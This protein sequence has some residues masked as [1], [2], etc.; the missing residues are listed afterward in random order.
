MLQEYNQVKKTKLNLVLFRFAIE[1]IS[2]IC[3]ILKLP[4]GNA[5]LVGVGGSGRQSLTLLSAFITE[6]EVFSIEISK[7]YSKVEWREDMKKLLLMTGRDNLKTVF[8]FPD[9]KIKEE[10]FIED[11]NGLLNSGDIPNLFQS[12]EKSQLIEKLLPIA[13]EEQKQGDSSPMQIYNYFIERVKKNLHIV[14]CMSPI[15]GI[16]R[17]RLRKFSSLVNCCTIDWFQRWPQDALQAVA[18]QFFSEIKIEKE[19]F[20]NVVDSCQYFHQYTITM[21]TKFLSA[22]NRYNYVTPT[23]YLELLQAYKLLLFK[24]RDQI[25][26]FRNRYSGGLEKL[27]FAAKQIAKMQSDLTDLQPQLK[28]TTE[29]TVTMLTK[30][31]KESVEVEETRKT[32]S[33]DEADAAQKAESSSAMKMECEN[34][35]AEAIPLL[36]AALTALDTLKKSDVDLVKSMKNPPAGVKLVMESICV[37]KDIKPDKI[38]DPTGSGKM[39]LDYWKP[40]QKLLGDPGFLGGL[41]TYDKDAIPTAVIKKIRDTYI[42]NP[43]FKPEKVKNASSAAE[44]LCSWV[45]A[46]EAYDRVIKVV[47]PKQAELQKAESELAA[48][49]VILNEKRSILK[50]VVERLQKLNDNLKELSDKKDR[51]EKEGNAKLTS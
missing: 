21:S 1:H 42:P 29:E 3:R 18:R 4:G 19:L 51:L 47:A 39:I 41:K 27:Q 45:L 22:L 25:T 43:E 10:S 30:I 28:K 31:A 15:G 14:L 44:G 11:V 16:F 48:T 36:N 34:D 17:D 50:S 38:P 26:T 46:M 24:Q 5:L 6:S 13:I 37:M 9:T 32:V 12:D 8:L 23:S 49:M 2:K 20:E 35:L 7:Q 33:A 40:S